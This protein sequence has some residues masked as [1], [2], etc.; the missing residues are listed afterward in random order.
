MFFDGFFTLLIGSKPDF[1]FS[2]VHNLQFGYIA[3]GIQI[4]D[5]TQNQCKTSNT[6]VEYQVQQKL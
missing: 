5:H 2:S 6:P 4:N 3:L 1:G